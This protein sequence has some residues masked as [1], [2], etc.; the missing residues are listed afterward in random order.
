MHCPHCSSEYRA[1]V[2]TC[3]D[4]GRGL[5]PGSPK[6]ANGEPSVVP[7]VVYEIAD[8]VAVLHTADLSH[9]DMAVSILRGEGI[10]TITRSW[11]PGGLFM[12][13][14]DGAPFLGQ[15]AAV[16]VPLPFE[17]EARE[18]L[19]AMLTPADHFVSAP[20]PPALGPRKSQDLSPGGVLALVCLAPAVLFGVVRLV[21]GIVRWVR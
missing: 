10:N 1:G 9:A 11:M 14:L 15:P 7:G 20:P 4:C 8:L 21:I 13:S 12:A 2:A 16:C 6:A 19:S 17:A 5:L 3:N 18:I